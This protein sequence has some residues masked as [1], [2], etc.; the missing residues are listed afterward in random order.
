MEIVIFWLFF[1]IVAGA[2]ASSK[3]RSGFGFFLLAIILSPLIGIICALLAKSNVVRVEREQIDDGTMRKCPYCAE[4]VRAE[5]I[6]CKHCGSALDTAITTE[7][8]A[9]I[10]PAY[11][12]SRASYSFGRWLGSLFRPRS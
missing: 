12:G 9:A 11:R 1:S 2:I 3:G 10:A 8:K 4:L 6:K 5:A 7:H